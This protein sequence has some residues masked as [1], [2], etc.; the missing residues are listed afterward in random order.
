M[1]KRIKQDRRRTD[2]NEVAHHLVDVSTRENG[3]TLLPTKDQISMLMSE[4]GRKGGKIGGK[5]RLQTMSAKERRAVAR[6]AAQA[7]WGTKE[8]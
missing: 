6:K 4:M 2:L 3:D 8:E 1:P 5:R 7:R